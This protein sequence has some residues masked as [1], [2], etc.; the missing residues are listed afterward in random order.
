MTEPTKTDIRGIYSLMRA[1]A[2]NAGEILMQFRGKVYDE[3]KSG[4]EIIQDEYRSMATAKTVVDEMIQELFLAELWN[5]RHNV[6]IN[7]EEKT[8][9]KHL[10]RNNTGEIV[11]HQD[12]CDGTEGYVKLKDDFAT[13][14]GISDCSGFTH[15]VIVRPA[16]NRLYFASPDEFGVVNTINGSKDNNRGQNHRVLFEKR[17]F[18]EEGRRVATEQGFEVR[19]MT[20]AHCHIPDVALGHAGAFLYGK[21]SPHDSLIP[22]AFARKC[23]ATLC[24]ALGAPID[25]SKAI[26]HEKDG[27]P[28]FERLPSACYFSPSNPHIDAVLRILGDRR[29]LHLEYLKEVDSK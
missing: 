26:V 19:G 9:L 28:V 16:A 6:R 15:T 25:T 29:N 12:P 22:Y 2:L 21:S 8:P 10:F 24:D 13:G 14:Y 5:G 18:S 20:S 17:L 4:P 1:Y 23:G 27:L 7:V 3:G 11:V